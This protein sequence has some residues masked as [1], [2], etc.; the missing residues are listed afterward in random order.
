MNDRTTMRAWACVATAALAMCHGDALADAL[1]EGSEEARVHNAI[2]L[3]AY[4]FDLRDVRLLDG[5]LK[6]AQE[7]DRRYLLSLDPNRLLY[8][9]RRNAGLPTSATPLG[10][11]ERP[12]CEL[13]G[14]FTGHYLTACALMYA[15]T[16]DAALKAKGDAVVRGLAECQAQFP[17]GYLSAFPEEYFDR[18][19]SGRRVWAPYYTLH[20]IYAGLLDMYLYCGNRQALEVCQK[21]ADWVVARTAQLSD[22]QMQR[23]LNVEHGGMNEVL[24]NLYGLTGDKRYCKAAQRFNHM[25]VIGPAENRQDRLTGLHANTQIP[26]FVGVARQYE[27]SGDP[28]LKTAATF[29]WETVVGERSYVIGG[30]SNGEH[31]SPKERLSEALGPATTETCNTYNMLK[32]TRHLF[33]WD[34]NVRY[35]D[36]YERALYNHILASQHPET[37]MMCYY[38]PLRSGSAKGGRGH[39]YSS[40]LDSFWCCT[41]TGIENH[42][43]YGDSIYFHDGKETLF[44]NL[45]I[46]S[47]LRIPGTSMTVRQETRFPEEEMTRLT[48]SCA[49]PREGVLKIRHPMWATAGVRVTVNGAGQDIESRPGSYVTLRRRWR[50]GDHVEITLPFRV[51]VE[52]FHDNPDRF[53]FLTGPLVLCAEVNRTKPFPMIVASKDQAVA[54]LRP[55]AARPNV[56]AGDP[57]VFRTVGSA[58]PIRVTLEPFYQMHGTRPY[59]VY[60]DRFSD[61]QWQAKE[62]EYRAEL[63]RQARLAERTVDSVNPGAQQSETAHE[64]QGEKT[65]AGEFSGSTYRHAVDG[66]FSYRLKCLPD[67]PQQLW[68]TYW[69]SDAGNRVFDVLVDGKKLIT[70]R[71]AGQHPDEFYD[72]TTPL[73][74]AMTTG[75]HKIT[76]RFQAHDGNCAG[77]VFGLRIVK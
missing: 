22:A 10:G 6:H 33:C 53:A 42:A 26:K 36:Y 2:P 74:P 17:S 29:F 52:G 65:S 35:A 48:L 24:A 50:D 76:V 8:T 43:K 12:D 30:N 66:W 37:G 27:L 41:G 20:K 38:V 75:K 7:L 58:V 77:G 57:G 63:A 60:W 56:F 32:L 25:A 72:E 46:A 11:W 15:S 18:V 70:Q 39:G 31:F 61:Q 49:S 1:T 5:P 21:F 28:K 69:G 67:Q 19:E 47:E 9:F 62:K 54:A 3:R 73:P 45:F 14:H 4:A 51:H 68:V 23:M 13:R 34:P 16:S 55:V 59:V 40:P 44:V 64:L 71:L